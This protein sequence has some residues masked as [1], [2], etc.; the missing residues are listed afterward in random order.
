LNS[1]DALEFAIEQIQGVFAVFWPHNGNAI[2]DIS[3][4]ITDISNGITDISNVNTD[5][6]IAIT[7]ISIALPLCTFQFAFVHNGNSNTVMYITVI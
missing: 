7:D 6:S 5:I 2:T 1:G 4:A 3:N